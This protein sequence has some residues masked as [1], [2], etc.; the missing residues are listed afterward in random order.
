MNVVR[1]GRRMVLAG[2]F[3]GAIWGLY[4]ATV[5]FAVHAFAHIP[6]ASSTVMVPFALFCM[7]NALRAGGS[8]RSVGVAAVTAA[9]IKLIDFLMGPVSAL[10]VVNP[11]VAIL[12]E[13]LAFVL[14]ATVLELPNRRPGLLAGIA[15]LLAFNVGWRICF[16]VYYGVIGLVWS[17]GTMAGGL[18]VP[19]GFLMRDSLLNTAVVVALVALG[20]HR[21]R[22][23]WRTLP[24]PQPRGVVLVVALAV[25]SEAASRLL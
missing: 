23:V 13:T 8:I 2:V 3:W 14:L 24:L 21:Q 10:T 16:L 6:G 18:R 19:L 4:E 7:F 25:L 22:E 15:A 5:G 11:A 9:S 20:R 1:L 17:V 12:L